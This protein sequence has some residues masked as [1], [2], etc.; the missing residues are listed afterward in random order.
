MQRIIK[1]LNP[2]IKPLKVEDFYA[3]VRSGA[4]PLVDSQDRFILF[5]TAKA[6][7][8][9]ATK[10]FFE[11]QGLLDEALKYKK[12]I[13]AYRIQVYYKTPGYMQKLKRA[14]SK[15][16]KKIKLVRCP[17]QRAVSSYLHCIRNKNRHGDLSPFLG[18]SVDHINT[19]TFEEFVE[20]LYSI[21]ITTCNPHY[22]KQVWEHEITNRLRF[23]RVIK[24]ES[25]IE[26]F[27]NI[28]KEFNLMQTNLLQHSV[29]N[30]H[31][32]KEEGKGGYCG[33]IHFTKETKSIQHYSNF[34][35][36]STLKRI[37]HIYNDDFNH[38]GY[39]KY[40]NLNY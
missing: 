35:N 36:D 25:S 3:N 26:E 23:Y 14:L 16:A 32:K 24:L 6:G 38:Y 21:D 12:W 39:S 34:Y 28:E 4:P 17:Y 20:F 13:H 9:F 10:W 37:A 27:R 33:N 11:Q 40:L 2:I 22:R 30:H 1:L 7:C 15:R 18:R 19:F 29:S 31:I 5:I 8:T